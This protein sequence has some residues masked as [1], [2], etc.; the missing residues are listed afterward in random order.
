MAIRAASH[1]KDTWAPPFIVVRVMR[2]LGRIPEEE[3]GHGLES[4]GRP[5]SLF[6]LSR[7]CRGGL[8]PRI[9][10]WTWSVR[11]SVRGPSHDGPSRSRRAF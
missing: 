8:S 7:V 9:E 2:S 1:R 3:T 11:A 5:S 4:G 10:N 6:L